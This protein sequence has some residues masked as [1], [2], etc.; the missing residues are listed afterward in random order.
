M[1]KAGKKLYCYVDESGQDTK[2]ALFFVSII[3]TRAENNNLRE[4]L[5]KIEQQSDKGKAQMDKIQAQAEN[6]IYSIAFTVGRI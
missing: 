5:E 2:G 3:L 4:K 6:R 1:P